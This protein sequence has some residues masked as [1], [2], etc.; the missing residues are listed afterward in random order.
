MYDLGEFEDVW[1][2]TVLVDGYGEVDDGLGVLKRR[3]WAPGPEKVFRH[4]CCTYATRLKIQ[5]AK[6]G[7]QEAKG[8]GYTN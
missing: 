4:Y 2:R 5:E 8:K 6:L 3:M 1:G 7:N